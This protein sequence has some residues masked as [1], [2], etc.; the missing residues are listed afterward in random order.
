[1][2]FWYGADKGEVTYRHRN[3]PRCVASSFLATAE[4]HADVPHSLGKPLAFSD[5]VFPGEREEGR[6]L[7]LLS[8]AF[9]EGYLFTLIIS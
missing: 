8:H 3:R 5:L 2:P 4:S 1:M 9:L 7:C 6:E